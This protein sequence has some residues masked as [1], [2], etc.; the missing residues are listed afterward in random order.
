ME[1]DID[2]MP[3]NTHHKKY[4]SELA[5]QGMYIVYDLLM[6]H[7]IINLKINLYLD[8]MIIRIKKQEPDVD[9]EGKD[10][11]TEHDEVV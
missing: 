4:S 7:T 5:T 9:I 2:E 1:L 3:D 10:S 6:F 11:S 8:K